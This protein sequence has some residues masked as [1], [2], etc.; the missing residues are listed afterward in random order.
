MLGL[1]YCHSFG[2]VHR[3]LKLANCA[4]CLEPQGFG[5]RSSRLFCQFWGLDRVN[6]S[7]SSG[8]ER[9]GCPVCKEASVQEALCEKVS[10]LR[11]KG[12]LNS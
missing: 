3:D 1:A 2:I 12:G 6:G 9:C 5:F 11:Q 8:F 7:W 4:L 10:K